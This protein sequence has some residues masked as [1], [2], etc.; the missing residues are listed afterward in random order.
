MAET[1]TWPFK[2]PRSLSSRSAGEIRLRIVMRGMP[3][4]RATSRMGS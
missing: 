2:A 4:T 1:G 3:A